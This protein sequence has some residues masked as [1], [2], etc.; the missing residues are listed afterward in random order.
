MQADQNQETKQ[1]SP[2]LQ[3]QHIIMHMHAQSSLYI[4]P[5]AN[6][7]LSLLSF[8]ILILLRSIDR[9]GLLQPRPLRMQLPELDDAAAARPR[10]ARPIHL[11]YQ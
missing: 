3:L 8:P 1:H 11:H 9:D 10:G 7:S 4:K 2:P 6:L 5:N